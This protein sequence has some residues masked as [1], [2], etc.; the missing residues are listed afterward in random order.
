M[1]S[2]C[3]R[4]PP[5]QSGSITPELTKHRADVP[6][7]QENNSPYPN[8]ATIFLRLCNLSSFPIERINRYETSLWQTVAQTPFILDAGKKRSPLACKRVDRTIVLVRF[9]IL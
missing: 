8:P 5:S 7:T 2:D 3:Y 6:N 9:E 4:F 1:A